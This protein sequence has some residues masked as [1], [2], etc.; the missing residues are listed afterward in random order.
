ME[1]IEIGLIGM[2]VA[3]ESLLAP[4]VIGWGPVLVGIAMM[5]ARARRLSLRTPLDWPVLALAAMGG[6]SA[7]VTP[8]PSVAHPHLMRFGAGLAAFYGLVYWARESRA[9]LRLAA[10]GITIG[11]LALALLAPFVVRWNLTKGAFIPSSAYRH[12][13]L[14][15]PDAVH[16]NTMAALM[17]LLGPLALASL[18]CRPHPSSGR[19]WTP[20]RALAGVAGPAMAL[21]LV[22]TK[23]RG[24]YIAGTLGALAV[25]WLS[26]RRRLALVATVLVIAGAACFIFAAAAHT[27]DAATQGAA[28]PSTWEFRQLVWR[29]A[30]WMI[31]D[32]PFTGVGMGAFN[33]AA[34][35]LYAFD[36]EQNPG[37]HNLYLQ[38]AVDLGLP[39]LIAMLSVLGLT[40]WLAWIAMQRF[41]ERG[42]AELRALAIGTLA[43]IAALMIHGLVDV[44]MWGT[45][46]GCVPWLVIGLVASLHAEAGQATEIDRGYTLTES[47]RT[48]AVKPSVL[49][50]ATKA[51]RLP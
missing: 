36:E 23:S 45:R 11:G 20:A 5:A 10:T 42:N 43:G 33:R 32:F 16:P 35:A 38:I 18:L 22:L 9:R 34:R 27:P 44:T 12:F 3:W 50:R 28:D 29:T 37:A 14:L 40:L 21:V 8:L 39:G 30:V 48:G 6:A 31:G 24:G 47:A 15:V 49:R 17:V 13:V 26:S 1:W 41:T 46:A 51:L 2:G 19:T 7:L 4:S 25:V